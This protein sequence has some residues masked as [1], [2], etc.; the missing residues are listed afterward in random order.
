MLWKLGRQQ[1]QDSKVT[2]FLDVPES[3]QGWILLDLVVVD[4]EI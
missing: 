2:K 1:S 3:V 4:S